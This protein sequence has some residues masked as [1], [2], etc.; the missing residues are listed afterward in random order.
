MDDTIHMSPSVDDL[1]ENN[2]LLPDLLYNMLAWII[3]DLCDI[4][5]RTGI[6]EKK[7]NT[8]LS[9]GQDLVYNATNG[10]VKTQKHISLPLTVKHLTGSAQNVTLLNKFGHGVSYTTKN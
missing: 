9:L 4:E 7:H 2:I 6:S 5:E 10:M 1:K 8:V 3:T